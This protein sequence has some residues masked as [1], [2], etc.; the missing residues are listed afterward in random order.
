MKHMVK[1]LVIILLSTMLLV[2]INTF[3]ASLPPPYYA[4]Y[5]YYGPPGGYPPP[6]GV[7]GNIYTIDKDG[8]Y[9]QW[10]TVMLSYTPMYWVQVGY[11]KSS[12]S[13]FK[14]LSF[15]EKKDENGYDFEYFNSRTPGVTYQYWIS[16]DPSLH[17]WTCGSNDWSKF[18]NVLKPNSA[19]DYQ[20]FSEMPL[21]TLVNIDGTHFMY[22]SYRIYDW[23]LWDRCVE[24]ADEPY[25]IIKVSNY[26]FY[27]GGG[28]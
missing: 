1:C 4:G 11:D 28:W 25:W 26:E 13:N 19:V 5:F 3:S 20:A 10:V 17:V 9:C 16:K 12:K 24:H 15:Y 14:L 22:L 8:T 6:N 18:L 7:K 21:P 27:A 23:W 2:G